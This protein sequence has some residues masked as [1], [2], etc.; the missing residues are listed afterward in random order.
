MAEAAFTG[1]RSLAPTGYSPDLSR[2]QI[3]AGATRAGLAVSAVALAPAA[4]SMPANTPAPHP[5]VTRAKHQRARSNA[6]FWQLHAEFERLNAAWEADDDNSEEAWDAWSEKVTE[7][8]DLMLLAPVSS[9]AAIAAKLR[10]RPDPE[11][12]NLPA[13]AGNVFQMILWDLERL[14]MLAMTG[15]AEPGELA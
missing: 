12:Y 6:R 2:R 13:P 3:F 14:S 5:T 15:I 8:E 7:A 1:G 4:L 9:A 11:G 10:A